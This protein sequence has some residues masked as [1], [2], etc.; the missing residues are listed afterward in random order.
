MNERSMNDELR[1]VPGWRTG[2]IEETR[3]PCLSQSLGP[4]ECRDS[5]WPTAQ[6]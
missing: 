4:S 6:H 2:T 3:N 1:Y 5:E